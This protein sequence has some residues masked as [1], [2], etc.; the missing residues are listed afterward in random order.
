MNIE[1][2]PSSGPE[3]IA[4][5]IEQMIFDG[6][7]PPGEKVREIALADH[8]GIGRA[9]VREAIRLLEGRR[10]LVRTRNAGVAVASLSL[11]DFEQLL[12]TREALEGMA[13]RYAAE[14]M[15]LAQIGELRTVAQKMEQAEKEASNQADVFVTRADSDFHRSIAL[16]SR[17]HW[18]SNL[19][20][21][22]LYALLKLMRF[23]SASLRPKPLDA[24]AEHQAII[25][26]IQQRDPEGAERLMREHIRQSRL[27]LISHLRSS[28]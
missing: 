1:I 14:N 21:N 25:D 5:H 24:H 27:R 15:T 11:D 20:C 23:R 16:G 28:C 9:P 4:A 13:A 18:I 26:C 22:D 7:L 3:E 17:N 6:H 8:L 2:Q 19:L 10:L 12:I